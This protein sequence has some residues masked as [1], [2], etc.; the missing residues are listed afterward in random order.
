MIKQGYTVYHKHGSFAAMLVGQKAVSGW[1][2]G[3]TVRQ[4]D[5]V[6]RFVTA[7]N[8][9]ENNSENRLR[10]QDDHSMFTHKTNNFC[11]MINSLLDCKK[12]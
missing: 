12:G 3:S 4:T 9:D 10:D 5:K 8:R 2:N 11:S 6:S 1:A 7:K